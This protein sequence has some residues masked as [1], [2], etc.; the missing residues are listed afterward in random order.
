MFRAGSLA[1]D[2]RGMDLWKLP[3]FRTESQF[4]C[5]RRGTTIPPDAFTSLILYFSKS[6]FTAPTL[7][8]ASP[9]PQ[10]LKIEQ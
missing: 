1:G 5:L 9:N 6:P 4:S 10:V 7:P 8:C 2:G 3:V